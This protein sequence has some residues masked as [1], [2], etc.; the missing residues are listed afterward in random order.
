M[1]KGF[2][3]RVRNGCQRI[4]TMRAYMCFQKL[5]ERQIGLP[6]S[7]QLMRLFMDKKQVVQQIY[8]YMYNKGW[9][10]EFFNCIF[11]GRII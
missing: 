11:I 10:I 3:V 2:G 9:L 5:F 1:Q 6:Y 8:S 4:V 7:V